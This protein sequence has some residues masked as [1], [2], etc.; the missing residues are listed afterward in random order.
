[1]TAHNREGES[2]CEM[3]YIRLVETTF[4]IKL[5]FCIS[6]CVTLENRFVYSQLWWYTSRSELH[7]N[8]SNCAEPIYR[9]Y[10][11]RNGRVAYIFSKPVG[12]NGGSFR[13]LEQSLR[14]HRSSFKV[15]EDH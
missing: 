13:R 9:D 12:P 4:G 15:F 14:I 8:Y 5:T 1:M 2:P 10:I 6:D 3:E 7:I 11:R